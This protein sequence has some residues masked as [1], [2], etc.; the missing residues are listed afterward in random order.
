MNVYRVV[1]P[2][3]TALV[4]ANNRDDAVAHAR[5]GVK[6]SKIIRVE[7]VKAL[8]CPKCQK[9][10][11]LDGGQWAVGRTTGLPTMCGSCFALQMDRDGSLD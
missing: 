2:V 7:E 6:N 1:Y 11:N 4:A 3:G 8:I 9:E 5:Q 10:K